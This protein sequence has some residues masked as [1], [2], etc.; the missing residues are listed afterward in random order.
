MTRI[1]VNEALLGQLGTGKYEA[2]LC[3]ATGRRVGYFLPDAVYRQLVCRWANTQVTDEEL[4]RCRQETENFTT[5]E[6]LDR[7]RNL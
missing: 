5:A 1:T 4:E 3:D 6:V 2:E 7:L